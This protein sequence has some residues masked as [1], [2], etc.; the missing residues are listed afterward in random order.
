MSNDD[1]S[2]AAQIT[3]IGPPSYDKFLP[4]VI[5]RNYGTWKYHETLAPGVL[6]HVAESGDKLYTVRAASPRLLSV[7]TLRKF[8]ELA[9]KYCGGFLRFTSR[10]NVEFLLEDAAKIEPLKQELSA[11]GISSWRHQQLHQQHCA[12]AGLGALPCG[13]H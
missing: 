1:N 5:R 4:P 12:H 2:A 8:A 6:C 10:N 7:Q 3:D 13:G 11:L 9:D